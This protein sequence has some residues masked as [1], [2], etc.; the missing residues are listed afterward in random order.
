MRKHA[1][2]FLPLASPATNQTKPFFSRPKY[3][4]YNTM[5]KR[6]EFILLDWD[7]NL[8][9]TLDVWLAALKIPL[10]KRGYNFTDK[11]IGA[12]F[13]V[14]RERMEALGT[15][16]VDAIIAEADEIATRESPQSPL[17]P[18]ALVT[19][20][21]LHSL[22]KK[23][24]LVTTSRHEQID[25]LLEKHS[26]HAFFDVVVCGDDVSSHK[27]DP[28]P[29]EKALSLLGATKDLAVM[30]GDSGSDIKAAHNA[31]IDSILFF[32]PEHTK[33][34]DIEKLKQFSPTYIVADFRDIVH[35]AR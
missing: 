33:F 30:V 21:K 24:A 10:Q 32:P 29:I 11:Q 12:N 3:A 6:Y 26:L 4:C 5:M 1:N 2:G 25:P 22:G 14:F 9:R 31:G 34:Y 13:A 18:D 16:N 19:L 20:E 8:A 27:P 15:Q 7:G 35:I 23:I 28:E 17:Y